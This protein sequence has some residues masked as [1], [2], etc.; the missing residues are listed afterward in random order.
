M[1][2]KYWPRIGIFALACTL[3]VSIY[4]GSIVCA[5][6][7]FTD[8]PET[9]WAYESV[10]YAVDHGYFSGTG[11]STFSPDATMTRAMLWTVLARMDGY[12]GT[13]GPNDPWYQN[14]RDW[15]MAN[16]I[17]DGTNPEGN[18][19]RE[20]FATMLYNFAEYT[21]ESTDKDSSILS[22]YSDRGSIASYAMDAMAWAVTHG[23]I[24]GTTS[25]TI[26]PTGLATRAQAAAMLMRFGQMDGSSE[27]ENPDQSGEPTVPDYETI[28]R[29]V[30]VPPT[31]VGDTIDV[32]EITYIAIG[33][34]P[35]GANMDAGVTYT[36]TCAD[37]AM[38]TIIPDGPLSTTGEYF[39]S[40][41]G[42]K[43]GTAVIT[44]VGSDGF[45]GTVTINIQGE[46]PE[47]PSTP[48]SSD[49]DWGEYAEMKQE[50]VDLINEERARIGL[51][52][53]EVS[54]KVMQAAQI[55]ADECTVSYSHTRPNGESFNTVFKEVDLGS[56]GNEN[57]ASGIGF[58]NVKEIVDA[59][60]ASPGHYK[61][62][63]D[64]ECN[65]IGI[66]ISKGVN[67]YYFSAL[68]TPKGD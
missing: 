42:L 62:L 19:T 55:R 37:S 9:H 10:E 53:L 45:R 15:A 16:G 38:V 47:E 35:Y 32:G 31:F 65:Y 22:K 7:R 6:T 8:V 46:T 3:C 34:E 67:R 59:W 4:A 17:S 1:N 60:F 52:E 54:P 18:I 14:G 26:A 68:F 49:I 39:Y 11:G 27:P 25:T 29:V 20:Q 21:G 5:E 40:V 56:G 43:A 36:L 23:I 13:A 64:S 63:T 24:S 33:S 30:D 41:R 12:T 58:N 44:A 50:I 57:L 2:K 51:N 28:F 48:G 61:A 66:G